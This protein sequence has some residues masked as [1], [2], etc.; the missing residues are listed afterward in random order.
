MGDVGS[1]IGGAGALI[2]GASSVASTVAG[3]EAQ[4]RAQKSLEQVLSMQTSSAEGILKQTSPLRS[5]TT[6]NLLDVLTGGSNPNLGFAAPTREAIESQFGRAREN[7][8]QTTPNQG[9]QLNRSLADLEIARA[10]SVG[11]LE[12]DTRRKAFEDSLRIGFGVAPQTVLPTFA[13]SANT[14]ATL[15]GQ[16]AQQAAAGGAGLGQITALGAL[17]S[18][19]GRS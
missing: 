1:I 19:K 9:G 5:V 3:K 16:G 11:G 13:G 6:A 10:Q 7:I 15:A 2:G 14:L 4:E 17:M 18:M 12:A 8:I